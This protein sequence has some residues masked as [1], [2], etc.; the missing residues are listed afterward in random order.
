MENALFST[1]LVS[2]RKM[3]VADKSAQTK[4]D[5][6][7]KSHKKEY[8]FV[9]ENRHKCNALKNKRTYTVEEINLGLQLIPILDALKEII[10]TTNGPIICFPDSK[11]THIEKRLILETGNPE[12]VAPYFSAIVPVSVKL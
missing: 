4:I 1:G 10:Y 8:D 9:M 2:R 11:P 3:L 6:W 7:R 5:N 12:S